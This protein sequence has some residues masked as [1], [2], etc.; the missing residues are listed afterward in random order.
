MVRLYKIVSWIAG[1]LMILSMASLGSLALRYTREM[2]QQTE[3]ESGRTVRL[4]VLYGRTVYVTKSEQYRFYAGFA[5][6]LATGLVGAGA[7]RMGRG[8]FRRAKNQ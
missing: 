1:A 5:L 2:P 7:D 4:K 6:V 8:R 3:V